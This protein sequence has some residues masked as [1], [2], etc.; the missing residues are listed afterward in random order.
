MMPT[1]EV[2]ATDDTANRES[3]ARVRLTKRLLIISVVRIVGSE[4]Q[5]SAF[6]AFYSPAS[7]EISHIYHVSQ[8]AD[9]S[10]GINT[11]EEGFCLFIQGIETH[12][13]T[14]QTKVGTNNTDIVGH[15]STYLMNTLGNEYFLLIR[16][17]AL[18]I[19]FGNKGIELIFVDMFKRMT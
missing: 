4:M 11:F 14:L 15:D 13:G 17:S 3:R 8:F 19:P 18:I 9:I 16:K 2:L 1:L 10:A 6:F 7:N 12:P 5:T